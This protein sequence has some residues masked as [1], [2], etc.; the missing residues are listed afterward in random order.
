MK[1]IVL[2]LATNLLIG[3]MLFF[4]TYI[5]G[6]QGYF[7]S[8]GI[9]YP[10]LIASS[11]IWGFGGAFISL[12]LSRT[13]AKWMMG[14]QLVTPQ[15]GGAAGRIASEVYQLAEKANLRAMPQV[16]I[17]ESPEMNAF[18]TGPSQSKSLVAV[19]TGLLE[20]MPPDQ[21]RAV[22]AHEIAH[23]KNGDMVTM[24][25]LQ[26]VVNS[27]AIFLA[28]IIANAVAMAVDNRIATLVYIGVNFAC[29]IAFTFLGSFITMA[30]SRQREFR[31]DAGAGDLVGRSSMIA[32]LKTLQA[33]FEPFDQRQGFETAKIADRSSFWVLQSSHPPIEKR[34][35]AL[36]RI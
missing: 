33:K 1:R 27:F 21:V 6:L 25:L 36:Q 31:A 3:T 11:L 9:N 17:Y 20:Q 10:T 29:Q 4:V 26:G 16:G 2:F 24:T 13:I 34:I 8:K 28:R 15:S 7:T 12:A 23:I 18:A 14:I 32:A 22:L 30:F 5:F 35:E 19:S